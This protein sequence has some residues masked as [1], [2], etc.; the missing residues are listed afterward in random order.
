MCNAPTV[1]TSSEVIIVGAGLAG[2]SLAWH[3][4]PRV[5]VTVLEQG[6]RAGE[7]ASAQNAGMVR[8]LVCDSDERRL[9]CRTHEWLG[10]DSIDAQ[11]SWKAADKPFRQTGAVIAF[12][13]AGGADYRR[14]AIAADDLRAQ[15]IEVV[16][17]D[18]EGLVSVAPAL[19]GAHPGARGGF[20]LPEDG[21]C[22]ARALSA[23]LIERAQAAGARLETKA[24]VTSLRRD[25]E[26]VCGVVLADGRELRA[27]QVVLATAAWTA[28]IDGGI[29]HAPPLSPLGRHL[30]FT[31]PS[32][33]AKDHPWV[34][35]EDDG[36]YL[37][38]DD[39]RFI[40][41][42]CDE[43]AVTPPREPGSRGRP[44]L[45]VADLTQANMQVSFPA[46]QRL[47]LHDGWTGLRT[48]APHRRA[49]LGPDPERRGLF[50]C[51]GLGGSGVSTA[52]G[53]GERCAEMLLSELGVDDPRAKTQTASHE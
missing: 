13:D 34:W 32:S 4:A 18:T 20:W 42:P 30:F 39:E 37:R 8:R 5:S 46:L 17:L 25:G 35:I 28:H 52:I 24:R 33:L 51:T 50:W 21:V 23:G 44:D 26:R 45:A 16:E 36:L 10:T 53:V 38:S 3:L 31:E 12:R 29:D 6:K 49:V 2:A 27:A 9:A 15:G 47:K 11:A 7:E 43:F 22:D 40:V 48:F 1:E 41:S 19:A 14:H